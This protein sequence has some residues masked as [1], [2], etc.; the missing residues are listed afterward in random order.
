MYGSSPGGFDPLASLVFVNNVQGME[1]N[2]RE[3]IINDR[4]IS[5]SP[6]EELAQE[7]LHQE[8]GFEHLDSARNQ[9]QSSNGHQYKNGVG[10][11]PLMQFRNPFLSYC[12]QFQDIFV[13][14]QNASEQRLRSLCQSGRLK[15]IYFR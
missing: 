9:K 6:E 13:F 2:G 14:G 15:P 7:A 4:P 12:Q 11:R 3:D 1:D 10:R 5:Q 8:E